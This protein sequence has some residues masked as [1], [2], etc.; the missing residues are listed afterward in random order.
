MIK[1]YGSQIYKGVTQVQNPSS[2]QIRWHCKYLYEGWVTTMKSMNINLCRQPNSWTT[3]EINIW[4]WLT[5]YIRALLGTAMNVF[6]WTA[7]TADPTFLTDLDEWESELIR[8][9]LIPNKIAFSS[10]FPPDMQQQYNNISSNPYT[11]V[12][13][14]IPSEFYNHWGVW[15]Y[16]EGRSSLS[17]FRNRPLNPVEFLD[18]QEFGRIIEQENETTRNTLNIIELGMISNPNASL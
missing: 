16:N 17:S 6:S 8:L 1:N 13:D 11:E 10:I 7:Q 9:T 18:R 2:L 5:K 3:E 15:I 12:H 14:C 4:I